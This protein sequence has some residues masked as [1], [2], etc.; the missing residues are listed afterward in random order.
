MTAD[1]ATKR[2]FNITIMR[3][4][5]Q[6]AAFQVEAATSEEAIDLAKERERTL[7]DDDWTGPFERA[8]YDD[9]K[10]SDSFRAIRGGSGSADM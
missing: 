6:V 3:P 8:I 2:T 7:K 9:D 1:N 10:Q 5:F 4:V